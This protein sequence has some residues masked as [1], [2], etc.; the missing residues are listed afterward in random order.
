MADSKSGFRRARRW[1]VLLALAVAILSANA[2]PAGAADQ[3]A[4]DVLVTTGETKLTGTLEEAGFTLEAFGTLLQLPLG[5]VS[6]LARLDSGQVR[7][8]LVNHDVLTGTLRNRVFSFST[9]S[10]RMTI[11][12][13]KVKSLALQ[14]RQAPP[15]AAECLLV[16]F[17]NGDTVAWL[18]N[19]EE[20]VI[21]TVQTTFSDPIRLRLDKIQEVRLKDGSPDVVTLR[22]GDLLYGR[23]QDSLLRVR[24]Y[25]QAVDVPRAEVA[26]LLFLNKTQAKSRFAGESAARIG[27]SSAAPASPTVPAAAAPTAAPGRPP[28]AAPAAPVRPPA[29]SGETRSAVD[30]LR[31]KTA[32]P[33]A[34]PRV[35]EADRPFAGLAYSSRGALAVA[36][37]VPGVNGEKL[38]REIWIY[39]PN[40]ERVVIGGP[41]EASSPAWSPDG[42][43]LAF[44]FRPAGVATAEIWVSAA[45]GSLRRQISHDGAGAYESLAWSPEGERLAYVARDYRTGASGV[46]VRDADGQAPRQLLASDLE[47]FS[48]LAWAP[49]GRRLLVAAGFPGPEARWTLKAI[50]LADGSVKDFLEAGG[51]VD[52]QPSWA[53]DGRQVAFVSERSGSRQIWLAN[54]DGTV[55]RQLSRGEEP[56]NFP[57]WSPD[58]RMVMSVAGS[59]G[60]GDLWV[61]DAAGGKAVTLTSSGRVCGA[62]GWSPD[63]KQVAFL[64]R[65][66]NLQL[67]TAVL[68]SE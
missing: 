64:K 23:L 25:Y 27:D 30:G 22:N 36:V 15:E 28:V 26:S 13:D 45:D 61:G 1:M 7:V 4:A 18:L 6:S 66:Q 31:L 41:G 60:R 50:D 24:T 19:P 63:G 67:W 20:Q 52:E 58:G 65:E 46:W 53:P 14:P 48:G 39:L 40:G 17:K 51:G 47:Y 5:F 2:F 3:T 12:A 44:A 35:A 62:P 21:V 29:A 55:L 43:W 34:D 42:R 32:V 16:T 37:G 57:V 11:P 38:G 49:D 9:P 56:K 59:D 8:E 33:L 10:A 54:S 68:A